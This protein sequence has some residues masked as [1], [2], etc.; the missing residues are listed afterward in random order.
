[1][2]DKDRLAAEHYGLDITIVQGDM[3][4]LSVFAET[5]SMWSG[6]P[7]PSLLC[8]TSNRSWPK[9]TVCCGPAASIAS[10]GPIRSYRP[11]KRLIGPATA[12]PL[13]HF[14]EDGELVLADTRW[15]VWDE[16]GNVAKVE[17]PR[18]FRHTIGAMVNGLVRHHMVILGLWE[19]LGD[20]NAEPGSWEHMKAIA[21]PWLTIWARYLPD[22]I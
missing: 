7:S 19:E 9:S 13:R 17:G 5:A 10:S 12:Y 15:D 4:D 20:R 11:W 16:E 1:M 18:E 8:P 6:T 2:L 22:V 14:Y 3:R 21:P